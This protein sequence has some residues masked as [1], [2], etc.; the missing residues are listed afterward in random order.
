M[1]A[2]GHTVVGYTPNAKLAVR[3]LPD[4]SRYIE[5]VDGLTFKTYIG[6]P[7]VNKLVSIEDPLDEKEWSFVSMTTLEGGP[8]AFYDRETIYEAGIH[9]N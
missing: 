2:E 4:L 7:F 9:E 6:N 1:A 8:E 5:Q 3:A